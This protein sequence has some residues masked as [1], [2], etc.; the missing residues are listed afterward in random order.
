MSFGWTILMI[1]IGAG[2]V[3]RFTEIGQL[4]QMFDTYTPH[5][6]L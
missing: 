2:V 5:R 4:G 1:G 3:L 6:A